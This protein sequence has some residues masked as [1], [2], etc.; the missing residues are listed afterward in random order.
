MSKGIIITAFVL[1]FMLLCVCDLQNPK[2]P[3]WN[4]PI[5]I[6][7][8]DHTWML[9]EFAKETENITTEEQNGILVFEEQYVFETIKVGEKLTLDDISEHFSTKIGEFE[10]N[11]PEIVEQRIALHEIYYPNHDDFNSWIVV[12]P[13]SILQTNLKI[14][15]IEDL[16][17]VSFSRGDLSIYLDNGLPIP[18]SGPENEIS[19]T[20]ID[21]NN[22]SV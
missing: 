7:L 21:A 20:I 9:D 4:V 11:L 1:H 15:S 10:M 14:N 3:V 8:A 17:E 2:H 18:L 12:S 13:F 5:T 16:L 6:P 22:H 19:I